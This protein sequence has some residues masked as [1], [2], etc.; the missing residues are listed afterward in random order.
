MVFL[1]GK[2]RQD[3]GRYSQY[4]HHSVHYSVHNLRSMSGCLCGIL[5]DIGGIIRMEERL[6]YEC[7]HQYYCT[8]STQNVSLILFN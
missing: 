7:Q 1:F 4:V 2:D 6:Q 3:R 8:E 5:M